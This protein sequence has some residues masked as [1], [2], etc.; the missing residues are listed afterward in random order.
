MPRRLDELQGRSDFFGAVKTL[1]LG[2]LADRIE[3][4][5]TGL[6]S[7]LL[8]PPG[9]IDELSFLSSCTRC[10]KC[11]EACPQDALIK[12]D[13]KTGLA[14]GTPYLEPR[15]TPCFLCTE[16]PCI[17]A[18]PEGAL[19]WPTRSTPGGFNRSGPEAVFMGIAEIH[20]ERCLTYDTEDHT[21]SACQVCVDRCP[22]PN[23]AIRMEFTEG[24]ALAHPIVVDEFCTGC[25]LCEFGCPTDP[26]AIQV[27]PKQ[28]LSQAR[29]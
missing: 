8:R 19:I 16:L 13:A 14:L 23:L 26:S 1:A 22:Y 10:D 28:Q 9:A 2:F 6:G 27:I 3:G 18:C 29:R 25:G 5:T 20:T 4:L 15:R 7:H 21:A 17:T 11:I 24:H 12:A